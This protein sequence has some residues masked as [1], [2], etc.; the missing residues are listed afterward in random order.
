[1]ESIRLQ[2]FL[3]Q[4][5]IAS[6][7]HAEELIVAGQ[8]VVNGKKVN[9]L[10]TKIDPKRDEVWLQGKQIKPEKKMYLLLNKP[11]GYVST[12]SDPQD[13]PTIF[14]ILLEGY[15]P[16]VEKK[17]K[18]SQSL[19]P[20]HS[21][22]PQAIATKVE[23]GASSKPH[24]SADELVRLFSVGRLDYN[25]EGALLLTNDGEL[26]HRLM[27]PRY[28]VEKLYH[29][30]FKGHL[31]RE[32]I[33]DLRQGVTLPKNRSEITQK[34]KIHRKTSTVEK[35]SP[36]AITVLAKTTQHTWLEIILH[37]GKNRQI[38]RMAE[39]IGSSLLK[40]AR[41]EYASLSVAQMDVGTYRPLSNHEV[42]ILYRLVGLDP[43]Q[44][45]R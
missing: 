36:A 7:R 41:L 26:A 43:E 28:G 37:E 2:R 31:N 20:I 10:G 5:G 17:P 1:M 30:K 24:L 42:E 39:A 34:A 32:Q 45:S 18:S 38:H 6:R 40:L 13:R 21:K 3:S 8:V 19:K 35:S 11:K 44:R 4:A 9:Q 16:P 29:A 23:K 14:N 27:H 25:T 12:A 33:Q 22:N 15:M